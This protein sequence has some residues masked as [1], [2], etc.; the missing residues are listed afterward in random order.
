MKEIGG[1]FVKDEFEE[2]NDIE[3]IDGIDISMRF[4]K[5][6]YVKFLEYFREAVTFYKAKT[7]QDPEFDLVFLGED[8]DDSDERI[9]AK[10]RSLKSFKDSQNGKYIKDIVVKS[11]NKNFVNLEPNV[12]S[13]GIRF[14]L[15][16]D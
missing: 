15:L 4:E 9:I 13:S 14:E 12:F 5:L 10:L 11:R 8:L 16:E 1:E 2:F 7:G 6:S 3:T